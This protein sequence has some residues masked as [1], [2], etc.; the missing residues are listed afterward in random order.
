MRLPTAQCPRRALNE[1]PQETMAD[2]ATPAPAAVDTSNADTGEAQADDGAGGGNAGEGLGLPAEVQ[3]P[4]GGMSKQLEHLKPK[5]P[6]EPPKPDAPAKHKFKFKV[7]GAESEEEL[8][9]DEIQVQLQKERA[10]RKRQNEV[11]AERKKF[12]AMRELGK[13]DPFAASK[14]LFGVDAMELA[15]QRLAEQYQRELKMQQMSPEERLKTEYEDKFAAKQAEFEALKQQ[16]AEKEQT[17]LDTRVFQETEANF[18]KALNTEGLPKSYESLA[19]MAHVAKMALDA[20]YHLTPEQIAGEVRARLESREEKLH[21][22][23]LSGLK[24]EDLL[25][26]FQAP[27]V[28]EIVR[29]VL[30]RQKAAAVPPP[31]APVRRAPVQKQV[32]DAQLTPGQLRKRRLGLI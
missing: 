2:N 27:V 15:Q 22:S 8:T 6:V 9:M 32:E 4:K 10:W 26:R 16:I 20:G 14:E 17:E 18:T 30:S 7:D 25:K 29:A 12:D 13:K 3:A 5:A 11:S 28:K 19:E 23:V 21:Q 31:S 1:H 24:G